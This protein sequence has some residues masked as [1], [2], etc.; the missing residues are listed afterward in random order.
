MSDMTLK[1]TGPNQ[2]LQITGHSSGPLPVNVELT[3]MPPVPL[4]GAATITVAGTAGVKIASPVEVKAV[5][6]VLRL[7]P[8]IRLRFSLFGFQLGEIHIGGSTEIRS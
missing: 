6:P 8:D 4:S 2:S 3:K 1:G 7:V 5:L